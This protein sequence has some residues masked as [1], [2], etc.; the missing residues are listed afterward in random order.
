M[1]HL[2]ER[3][4]V[5][6]NVMGSLKKAPYPDYPDDIALASPRLEDEDPWKNFAN[7]FTAAHGHFV[8]SIDSLMALLKKHE[9]LVGCCDP[10][11][12]KLVTKEMSSNF[13]IT[14]GFDRK[15]INK[16]AFG[17][18]FA[19]GVIAESGTLILN[20]KDTYSR[21]AALA[22]WIH[23][24]CVKRLLI[25]NSIAEALVNQGSDSNTIWVS[26]PSKTAD[27]EGILIEGVHGPGVQICFLID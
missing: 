21:L 5:L 17:M 2:S 7:N 18:T 11:L 3:N 6:G 4:E 12:K 10:D 19:S 23:V 16:F 22:P 27:V 8:D 25:H 9:A 13:D 14:Y 1:G 20:D 26:G 24:A 15:D